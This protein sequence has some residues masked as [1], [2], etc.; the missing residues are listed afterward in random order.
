V[1]E[2]RAGERQVGTGY[3]SS[4][5]IFTHKIKYIYYMGHDLLKPFPLNKLSVAQVW[6]KGWATWATQHLSVYTS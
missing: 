4:S 5:S 1:R 2:S 3:Y 6:P